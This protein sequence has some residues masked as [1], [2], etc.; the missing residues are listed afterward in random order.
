MTAN[1]SQ[2]MILDADDSDMERRGRRNRAYSRGPALPLIR[3]QHS[4][5]R[6]TLEEI[7]HEQHPDDSTRE[8]R[9][10]VQLMQRHLEDDRYRVTYRSERHEVV[11]DPVETST[12]P[13]VAPSTPTPAPATET[14]PA[15]VIKLEHDLA[16]I[17]Q[18]EPQQQQA[19]QLAQQQTVMVEEVE[20]DE[21]LSYTE[22]TPQPLTEVPAFPGHYQIEFPGEQIEGETN[23]DVSEIEE[24]ESLPIPPRDTRPSGFAM[25]PPPRRFTPLPPRQFTPPPVHMQPFPELRFRSWLADDKKKKELLDELDTKAPS[26]A[27]QLNMYSH[28]K[29]LQSETMSTRLGIIDLK[30]QMKE[31]AEREAKHRNRQI[32]QFGECLQRQQLH[33]DKFASS[34]LASIPRNELQL[35]A[36]TFFNTHHTDTT[37]MDE[38]ICPITLEEF[39]EK[40]PSQVH[41]FYSQGKARRGIYKESKLKFYSKHIPH[42]Q[43]REF[44]CQLC[45]FYRH[46]QWSCPNYV[47]PQCKQNCGHR[48]ENCTAPQRNF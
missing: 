28:L 5:D 9:Q 4:P 13:V 10:R 18:Q 21:P 7:A 41:L 20:D 27:S 40:A 30:K 48:C 16:A 42:K 19:T 17:Q 24:L 43:Y 29:N 8:T 34:L 1:R 3:N 15:W 44:K 14:R 12:P 22:T 11:F 26:I 38:G 23:S 32:N 6:S 33:F 31:E 45:L 2:Y 46:I 39:R 36:P 35:N 47:C 37:N 25:P